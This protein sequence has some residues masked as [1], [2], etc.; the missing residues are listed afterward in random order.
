MPML[1][2]RL[3]ILFQ[4]RLQ[5]GYKLYPYQN[6]VNK[7]GKWIIDFVDDWAR[8]EDYLIKSMSELEK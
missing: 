3:S 7:D 5:S 2:N 8:Y 4:L 1:T 6:K